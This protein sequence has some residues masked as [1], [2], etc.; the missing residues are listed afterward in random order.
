MKKQI[1]AATLSGVLALGVVGCGQKA[2][3]SSESTYGENT[4]QV[5]SAESEAKASKATSSTDWKEVES[6]AEAAK[7][8][9][10]T[11]FGVPESIT[12]AS[13]KYENPNF[14]YA[15]GVA[16]AVY[17]SS[18]S[19]VIVCKADGTH[20]AALTEL[21]TAS[22]K[23]TWTKT[24]NGTE[25]TNY[26]PA[27]GAIAVMTWKNGTAEYGVT[28]Q[29]T[30]SEELTMDSDEAEAIVT[31]VATADVGGSTAATTT[32]ETS[33]TDETVDTSGYISEEE[34]KNIAIETAQAL[35]IDSD[36]TGKVELKTDGDLPLYV[37]PVVDDGM[38]YT[39][40]IVANTGAVLDVSDPVASESTDLTTDTDEADADET[41]TTTD[42]DEDGTFGTANASSE[43]DDAAVASGDYI[44]EDTA[45]NIAVS[46]A[47][48]G[49]PDEVTAELVTDGDTPYYAVTLEADG[50]TKTI[51]INALTSDLM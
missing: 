51:K 41:G 9:G 27:R 32:D 34:A 25:V 1:V 49:I 2:E 26:G 31:A 39:F 24:Y 23:S 43:T 19:E 5:E 35:G 42:T 14:S 48:L 37:V 40:E 46:S 8:A 16:R 6:A 22:F 4:S 50:E 13:I 3:N 17:A 44:S 18:S 45:K 21:D 29:S 20:T 10:F 28:Y 15:D 11:S 33:S 30:G 7:G 12:V 36:E 38:V 47:A